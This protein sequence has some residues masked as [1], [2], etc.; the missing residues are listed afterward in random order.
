MPTT[1]FAC[2]V[3]RA[4]CTSNLVASHDD[5]HTISMRKQR[6]HTP[7]RPSAP[8]VQLKCAHYNLATNDIPGDAI[9]AAAAAASYLEILRRFNKRTEPA[10]N[11]ARQT[12]CA[13]RSVIH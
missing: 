5:D 6:K 10:T 1:T 7:L 9:V 4:R 2:C 8:A 11:D 12:N 3:M 13:S